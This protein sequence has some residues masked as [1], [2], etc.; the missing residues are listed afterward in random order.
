MKKQVNGSME[1]KET[2]QQETKLPIS[3]RQG[4]TLHFSTPC[5]ALRKFEALFS[6]SAKHL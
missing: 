6:S 5:E 1:D 4:S 3:W 2:R